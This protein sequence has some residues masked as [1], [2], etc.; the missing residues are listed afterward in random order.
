MGG[1]VD[2]LGLYLKP[3]EGAIVL[4]MDEETPTR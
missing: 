2:V 1:L 3:R 4:A